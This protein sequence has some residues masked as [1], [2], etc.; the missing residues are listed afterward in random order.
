MEILPLGVIVLMFS[1]LVVDLRRLQ[2]LQRKNWSAI[3]ERFDEQLTACIKHQSRTDI[4][5]LIIE[6]LEKQVQK[7]AFFNGG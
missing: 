2:D 1:W 7:D 4:N 5:E 3:E 6:R